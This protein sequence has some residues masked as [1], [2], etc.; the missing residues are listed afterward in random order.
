M[1]EALKYLQL[2]LEY[3]NEDG[4]CPQL[5]LRDD[6]C[7]DVTPELKSLVQFIEQRDIPL[8]LA[9]IPKFATGSLGEFVTEHKL[10]TPAVHGYSH[11]NHAEVD[12]KKC[13]FCDD[14][15]Q[16]E[17]LDEMKR[18]RQKLGDLFAKRLSPLFV[19]PWNRIGKNAIAASVEAGFGGISGFGWKQK[20]DAQRW[21]NTHID[22]I[23]WKSDKTGKSFDMLI[24]EL[25]MNLMY[26][27]QRDFS[28]VGI[29]T[30]HL[31]QTDWETLGE[32]IDALGKIKWI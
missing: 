8:L 32:A 11:T 23:D 26:S 3:W 27:R 10:I 15:D 14:R 28:P 22:V 21:V 19:P 6:D 13:E 29:L 1:A 16:D 12:Q 31:V 9:V 25:R 18:G 24:N 2:E 17:M 5:F 7:V 4:V 20:N 30:H